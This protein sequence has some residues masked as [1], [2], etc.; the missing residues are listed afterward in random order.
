MKQ[1]A[2]YGF[3]DFI[4]C[5]GYKGEMI[6]RYFMDY[7]I[8]QSDITVDLQ[9][10]TVE[11]H[12]KKTEDWNISVVDTGKETTIIERIARVKEYIGDESFI[13]TYGDCVSNINVTEM[14]AYHQNCGKLATVAVAHP[15]GRN[16]M[17]VI[18]DG[19]ELLT[20]GDYESNIAWVNACN[21]IYEPEVFSLMDRS[22]NSFER[23]LF[24][25]LSAQKE[26][27]T[28]KHAGFWSPMETK[29]DRSVLEQMWKSGKAPW[30]VWGT[31]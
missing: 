12:H 29:R 14:V 21:M 7:Y 23:G 8:Y 28:Y 2:H 26:I 10:N 15:T 22:Q 25:I 24:E 17:M 19:N 9:K 18:G 3:E 4:I 30:K 5:T 6:K 16:E 20:H 13:V 11:I 31:D 1:Y 27:V